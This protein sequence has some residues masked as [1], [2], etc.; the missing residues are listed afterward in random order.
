MKR[1]GELLHD[2]TK[3]YPQNI[4]TPYGIRYLKSLQIVL[5]RLHIN[6]INY[7][8]SLISIL[9]RRIERVTVL[10]NY[11]AKSKSQRKPFPLS[12]I[13]ILNSC[14]DILLCMSKI[15]FEFLTS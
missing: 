12:V 14:Q 3:I 7:K 4:V 15:K 13:H 2:L 10:H 11:S 5:F 8:Q 6:K 1:S 9:I